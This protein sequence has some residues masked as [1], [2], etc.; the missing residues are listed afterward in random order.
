MK[1]YDLVVVGAGPAGSTLAG[2]VKKHDQKA[3]V[4]IVDKAVFPRHHV[5]ESLLPGMIPVL[6]ELGVFEK[7]DREGF[8]RKV[9]ATF[10]WGKDRK[11][12]TADFVGLDPELL[13]RHGASLE[14]KLVWQVLRSRYDEILLEHARS[15]G[16]EA[17][18][19]WRAV[20]PLEKG[21]AVSG[22]LLEDPGGKRHEV[23]SRLLADCSGQQSFLGKLRGTRVFR[24][25]LKNVAAYG[26]FRGARWKFELQ[27]HPD[28][29]NIFVCS[30]P[31]GWLWYIPLS[32]DLVS[33]GLVSKASELKRRKVKDLRAH[34]LAAVARCR[35]VAPLLKEARLEKGVDP[36]EPGKD[37]FTAGD[38]SYASR[39]ACGP[40]W[41]AAGDAAFFI[42][43]LLSSGVMM[44][45]VSAHKAA[46]TVN[47][48]RASKDPEFR[49]L[50]WADYDRFCA[51]AGGTFL[52]LVS[53]WYHAE[54]NAAA[55]W[56]TAASALAGAAP[57]HL[58]DKLSFV[59]VAAGLSYQFERK[60]AT[61][62]LCLDE[63][64]S[65]PARSALELVA[66]D[67]LARDLGPW[68]RERLGIART[69]FAPVDDR[70]PRLKK[71]ARAA[72]LKRLDGRLV[73]RWLAPPRKS[74]SFLPKDG[75]L[76]PVCRVDF[77]SG[78]GAVRRL[79]PAAFVEV[80]D[81]VDGRRSVAE[82]EEAV[83]GQ[84]VY[85][86][87]RDLLMAG[88]LTIDTP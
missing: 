81:L 11:P 66:G 68:D 60:Y 22:V 17:R 9:G 42:D 74:V 61:E 24:D 39:S 55:W 29:T 38:W 58:G 13:A 35:E 6:R 83:P 75:G 51:E 79:L 10:V 50:A 26:Y 85:R 14:G 77:G 31:E 72:A 5:G 67:G 44:A 36:A 25:D 84:R 18:L 28:K 7:L 4:L 41:L 47:A 54:P 45:H 63:P 23:S 65:R 2:L 49:R 52:A 1:P 57:A 32:R 82:L 21:G 53:H 33:V 73:P 19:G 62:D 69:G 12:W 86:L 64:G 15:L 87:L 3:R 56:K 20:S 30:V 46:C 76:A 8:P 78:P 40:G 27:G 37:F 48:A 16:A 59:A 71:A 70:D 80:L 34:Y 43:P 88:V